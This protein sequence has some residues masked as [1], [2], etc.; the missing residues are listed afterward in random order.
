LTYLI[1]DVR[2]QIMSIERGRVPLPRAAIKLMPTDIPGR[3]GA[4]VKVIRVYGGRSNVTT[5]DV[6][7]PDWRLGKRISI[8]AGFIP[9]EDR[10]GLHSG[11]RFIAELNLY[12]K[13]ARGLRATNYEPLSP[14]R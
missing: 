11:S 4:E 8:S 7:V 14:S 1:E 5:I 12:A 6:E 9:E 13:K 2:L 3:F 10:Q